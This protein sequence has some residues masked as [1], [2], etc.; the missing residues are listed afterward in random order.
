MLNLTTKR[1][2]MSQGQL[3][4][5]VAPPLIKHNNKYN[6]KQPNKYHRLKIQ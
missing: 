4:L 3:K 1:L 2:I 6:K 5:S